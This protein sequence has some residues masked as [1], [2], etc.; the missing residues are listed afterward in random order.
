MRASTFH[1]PFVRNCMTCHFRPGGEKHKYNFA[2]FPL[3]NFRIK[4]RADCIITL[5]FIGRVPCKCEGE[6]TLSSR[7]ASSVSRHL[8]HVENICQ[9]RLPVMTIDKALHARALLPVWRRRRAPRRRLHVIYL[10]EIPSCSA[11]YLP[12][13]VTNAHMRVRL[14]NRPPLFG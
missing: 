3:D 9:Q 5:Q 13:S 4:I 2:Q 8:R 12:L 7:R 14:F 1:T 6:L 11:I 10:V